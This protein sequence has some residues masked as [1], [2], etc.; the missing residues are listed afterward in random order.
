MTV[1]VVVIVDCGEHVDGDW[2]GCGRMVVPMVEDK[3]NA[4][5]DCF[6]C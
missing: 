3:R 2:I 1:M 5:T 4:A 6:R